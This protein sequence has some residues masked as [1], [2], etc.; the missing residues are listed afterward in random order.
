MFFGLVFG[1]CGFGEWKRN[2][3]T[4][5]AG[6]D[7]RGVRSG[8]IATYLEIV[9]QLLRVGYSIPSEAVGV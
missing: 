8:I 7:F 5:S 1:W 4:P 9:E 3:R 6:L 2:F